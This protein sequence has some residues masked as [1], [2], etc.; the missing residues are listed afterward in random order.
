MI[1]NPHSGQKRGQS[2]LEGVKP[3]FHNHNINLK[4]LETNKAGHAQDYAYKLDYKGY[5][6]LC[7]IGGDG[8]MHEIINGMF[9]RPDKKKLPIGL[10][11]GG[12]GNS[13]MHDLN[14]LDSLSAA[15]RIVS[16]KSRDIDIAEINSNGEILYSFNV[17]G[18]GMPTDI[19]MLAEKLR[20]LG[21][22][23]YN[24]AAIIEVLRHKQ[25]L[26]KINIDGSVFIDDFCFVLGC[27]TIHTG[28]GMKMAPLATLND[29]MIDL[30]IARKAS[31]IKL[32]RLFPKLFSGK[33]IIDQIVDYRQVKEFTVMPIDDCPITIDGEIL[34]RTP[35]HVRV[36]EKA[37]KVLV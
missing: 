29:G 22:Q 31:R 15:K 35:I 13:Y 33:H 28:K 23:R 10:I 19:T 18:W 17:V 2:I 24:I 37:L 4:I 34:G 16:G 3:I 27:N 36:I 14:C 20:W 8:T 26:A 9:K 25:R 11:T 32:L 30:I 12:T 5:D 7:I 1:V 6:G 21:G